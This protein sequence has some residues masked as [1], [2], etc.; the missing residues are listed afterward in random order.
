MISRSAAAGEHGNGWW[1][2]PGIP[3]AT[4]GG[5]LRRLYGA[6]MAFTWYVLS[7]VAPAQPDNP[8]I[9]WW[10]NLQ[11][12]SSS[13]GVTS[14]VSG[15]DVQK[16]TRPLAREQFDRWWR[17]LFWC[18][19]GNRQWSSCGFAELGGRPGPHGEAKVLKI[20]WSSQQTLASILITDSFT[21]LQV[22]QV[23][24]CIIEIA[25]LREGVYVRAAGYVFIQHKPCY[26]NIEYVLTAAIIN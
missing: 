15:K 1:C 14:M 6:L 23:I 3:G 16:K 2:W 18:C 8:G 12:T 9:G 22:L 19:P 5:P 21:V 20:G 11:E 7:G 4:I 10:Q 13:L 26:F 25:T 24:C 17:S